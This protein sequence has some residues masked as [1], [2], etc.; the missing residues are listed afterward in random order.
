MTGGV[1]IGDT[2]VDH[3]GPCPQKTVDDPIDV[4]F[5]ARDRVARQDHGVGLA[6]LHPLV[7][8]PAQQGQRRHRLT[9]RPGGDHAH[10]ARRVVVDVFDVDK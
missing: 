4:A 9:L 3:L 6:D 8:A 10:L 5:V 2:G 7:L 1:H